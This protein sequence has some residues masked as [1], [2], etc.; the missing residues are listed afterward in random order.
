[1][2]T[3]L[4]HE[5]KAEEQLLTTMAWMLKIM[6]DRFGDEVYDVFVKEEGE[7]A[8]SLWKSIGEKAN[9]NSI[10]S[11]IQHLWEPLREKGDFEYTVEKTESGVQIKCTKCHP[12]DLAK[13]HGITEQVYYMGCE[14]DPFIVEGFNPNI[15]FK[16]TKTLMQGDDCCDHFYYYKK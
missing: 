1:M 9:D 14:M 2:S 12:Y 8:R 4:T 15:G 13:Q 7:N 16:R 11:L 5:Q 3:E 10:E 6:K